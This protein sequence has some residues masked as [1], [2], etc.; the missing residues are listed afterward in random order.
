M[1]LATNVAAAGP[2]LASVVGAARVVQWDITKRHIEPKSGGLARRAQTYEEIITNEKTRGGYF[3]TC[4]IGTPAQD[5]TLQLDTGSSDIWVPSSSA[6]VCTTSSSSSSSSSSSE[7]CTL[8]SFNSKKST[9]F[10]DV[11]PSLF[12][13]SY[14]DGSHSKGDYFTDVFEIGGANLTNVTMGLG[15]DTDIPYGLVGVGYAINEAIVAGSAST[16]SVYPNLPVVMKNEGMIATTAYSLWLNDLDAGTGSIL[17]GGIDTEKYI[18]DLSRINIQKDSQT[19]TFSSFIVYLTSLA[20]NSSSGSDNLASRQFPIPVVLDSGTTLSYLPNDLANQIWRE[21]GAV[22][23]SDVEVAVIPCS[24]A[25]SSGTFQFGFAGDSGPKISVGMDELV[26]PLVISGPVPK[27]SDGAY[28]GQEACQ[29]GIQNFSSDPF[30]LGDTFLRSAY[31]VYDL[32]N[33]Q[34]GMAKTDF[35]STKTNIVAFSSDSAQIPSATAVPNQVT[36]SATTGSATT[37]TTLLASAGFTD[38]V[39]SA[40]S[41]VP[42]FDWAQVAVMSATMALMFVGSGFFLLF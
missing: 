40:G 5:L 3:A 18:G 29:F 30:L 24:M 8:G 13:I 26:L 14:V 31:V 32:A 6:S 38:N 15:K 28:K 25:T 37:P 23:S 22:Y 2:L 20:A 11:G 34:I 17:F 4:K 10:D 27:F 16:R 35:N 1:R 33:N 19:N 9:T 36:S 12:S 41:T 7:G 39:K 21:V 42:T